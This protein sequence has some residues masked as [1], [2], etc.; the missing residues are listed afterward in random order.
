M[1]IWLIVVGDFNGFRKEKCERKSKRMR[2]K[3]T[4]SAWMY[5]C[6]KNFNQRTNYTLFL[7]TQKV[8]KSTEYLS[9]KANT[10]HRHNIDNIV[11]TIY[12]RGIKFE[13]D[14]KE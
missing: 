10:F 13:I 1:I 7:S 4:Q 5:I 9:R 14:T 12:L 8:I 6:R 2:M 11:E 3:E